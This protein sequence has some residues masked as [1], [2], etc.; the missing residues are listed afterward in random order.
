MAESSLIIFVKSF[1]VDVMQ[2]S[3][4]AS[5]ILQ[6]H[7]V[8]MFHLQKHCIYFASLNKSFEKAVFIVCMEYVI[9]CGY[10]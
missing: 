8:E 1:I 5:D 7:L 4:F 6:N 10:L 9:Q 2:G 3:E